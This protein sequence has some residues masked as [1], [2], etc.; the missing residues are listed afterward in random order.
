MVKILNTNSEIHKS[1]KKSF[2]SILFWTSFLCLCYLL[3][4]GFSNKK[5]EQTIKISNEK[6]TSDISPFTIKNN[7]LKLDISG[8]QISNIELFKYKNKGENYTLLKDENN[9]VECGLVGQ[10]T[11]FF[12]KN[13]KW[14]KDKSGKLIW[15]NSDNVI[16]KNNTYL[17][18]YVLYVD[19]EITNNS[20]KDISIAPYVNIFKSNTEKKNSSVVENG[21]VVH[22][23]SK[24][25]YNSYSN[26]DNSFYSYQTINGYAGFTDQY[27]SII[28]NLNTDD[29]TITLKK[30]NNTYNTNIYT[31]KINIKQGETKTV[32]SKIY[33]GPRDYKILK[34]TDINNITKIVDYGW[35]WF[36]AKPIS[37]CLDYLNNTGLNYGIAIIFLTLIIRLLMWPLTKKSYTSMAKMQKIQPEIAKAQKLYANDKLKLQMEILKIYQTNKTSPA[38]GCLPMLLQI[39]IFF[40]L[41]K[42][43]LISVDMRNANFLWIVDLSVMDPFFILPILMG[44]TIYIQQKIQNNSTSLNASQKIFKYLPIIF[45]FL[46]AFMPAGLILYWTISNVFSILQMMIIK[47]INK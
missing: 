4:F 32:S 15:K 14:T 28:A 10:G 18:D 30:I 21:A 29:Q 34:T 37:Y 9:F 12:N 31:D 7:Y 22:Y 27:F 36:F 35:F 26:L 5:N 39:P 6:L 23:N 24:L 40:A 20:K 44:I 8:N 2:S 11:T 16:F 38:S 3:I 33:F 47:K 19:Y 1:S 45:T 17:K 42:A 46:F 25:K 41:Y 13:T 43:L